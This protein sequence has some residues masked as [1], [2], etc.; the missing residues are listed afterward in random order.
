MGIENRFHV[1]PMSELTANAPE[2][3][4][5]P[6]RKGKETSFPAMHFQVQAV[7]FRD[8][9]FPTKSVRCFFSPRNASPCCMPRAT[10]CRLL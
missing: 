1:Q 3:G 9:S 10:A 2:N 4:P 5:C 6:K 8:G 7:S